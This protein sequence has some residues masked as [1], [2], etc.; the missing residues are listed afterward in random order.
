MVSPMTQPSDKRAPSPRRFDTATPLDIPPPVWR[1]I[2][3]H[4]AW[5]PREAEVAQLLIGALK[6]A[7]IARRLKISLGTLKKTV[8]HLHEKM[9]VHSRQE[10]S[11]AI[12]VL[13]LQFVQKGHF[14]PPALTERVYAIPREYCICAFSVYYFAKFIRDDDR[15][16][17]SN[18][19]LAST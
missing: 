16:I 17:S 10:F 9:E 3:T 12:L 6:E 14:P 4:F 1:R 2:A 5:S 18:P 7:A 13:Y 11:T 15:P 8:Q 19:Q